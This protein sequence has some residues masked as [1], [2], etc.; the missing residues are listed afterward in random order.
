M[1]SA[2]HRTGRGR[3]N[4]VAN[5]VGETF[6]VGMASIPVDTPN[7][8]WIKPGAPT[9]LGRVPTKLTLLAKRYEY[10]REL[11]RGASAR[12][13]LVRDHRSGTL[14]AAKSVPTESLGL[15]EI[16]LRALEAVAHPNL[17]KVYEL[18]TMARPL[19]APFHLAAGALLIQEFVDG[20]SLELVDDLDWADALDLGVQLARALQALHAAG[21]MHGDVKPSNVMRRSDGTPVLID[22]GLSGPPVIDGLVRGTPGFL[23]PEGWRGVRSVQTDVFALGATLIDLLATARTESGSSIGA[24]E[25]STGPGPSVWQNRPLS[26]DVPPELGR[27]LRS[28][29][30]PRIED[31]PGTMREALLRLEAL[32]GSLKV[33]LSASTEVLRDRT[34]AERAMSARHAPWVGDV[35]LLDAL[36][37]RLERGG[38]VRVGGPEGSGRGRLIQE[39]IGRV[40]ARARAAGRVPP[41]FAR[42]HIVPG[43]VHHFEDSEPDDLEDRL[44]GAD[45]VSLAALG[46]RT[47][48]ALQTAAAD[49]DLQVEPLDE[50]SFERLA[51][52]LGVSAAGVARST[53][54]LAGRL[55]RAV[56]DAL[57]RGEDPNRPG[58]VEGWLA[59]ETAQVA[60]DLL[61]VAQSLALGFELPAH[62]VDPGALRL[63][64]AGVAVLDGPQ[65]RLRD[66]VVRDLVAGL[67]ASERVRCA[68]T[69]LQSYADDPGGR[70]VCAMAR[71][72]VER[73]PSEVLG[74]IELAREAGNPSQAQ[75]LAAHALLFADLDALRVA[76][77][78]AAR[79]LGAYRRAIGWLESGEVAGPRALSPEASAL[80]AEIA[81]RLGDPVHESEAAPSTRAWLAL[82]DNR[83]QDAAPWIEACQDA[84]AAELRAWVHL[85]RG[86]HVAARAALEVGLA[87]CAGSDRL[88]RH[89]RARLLLTAG[90]VDQA[91]G[92]FERSVAQHTQARALAQQIGEAHLA[93]SASANCGTLSLDRGDL[94]AAQQQLSTAGSELMAIGRDRDAARTLANLANLSLLIGDED[95]VSVQLDAAE[96]AAVRAADALCLELCALLRGEVSLRR[97]RVAE[98]LGR[99]DRFTQAGLEARWIALIAPHDLAQA[100]RRL[101]EL[102]PADE[103]EFAYGYAA[104]RVQLAEGAVPDSRRLL[105]LGASHRTWE[106]RLWA[107]LLGAE[108]ADAAGDVARGDGYAAQAR[109][110]LDSAAR[111]LD[112]GARTR[113]RDVA[114]YR[115]AWPVRPTSDTAD[116]GSARWR[117]LLHHA[118]RVTD[119]TRPSAIRKALVSAA[120]ELVAA[121]RGFLV[122]RTPLGE[123]V[124]RAAVPSTRGA[125]EVPSRSV[126][127]RALEAGGPLSTMDALEDERLRQAG[128]VHALALRSVLAVPMPRLAHATGGSEW[129]LYLDDRLRPAAFDAT[130]CALLSDLADIGAIALEGALELRKS[131]RAERSLRAL[132]RSLEGQVE[133]QREE[134]RVRRA[135]DVQGLVVESAKMKAVMDLVRR[136]APSDL[137]V[138]VQGESGV[139]KER[140]A[141]ALHDESHRSTG[142][143]VA[144]S[145]AALPETLLESVLFGHEK[146]AFSGAVQ[147]HRGLFELADGGTLFLDE[148][149]EMGAAMQAKL[150][151]VLQQGE[152]R[153]VGGERVVKVDVR[154]VGAGRAV[155]SDAVEAGRF[156]EDLYYRLAVVTIEVPPLRERVEDIAPLV[157]HLLDRHGRSDLG[158][159]PAAMSA[160]CARSWPGNVRELESE[161][162]RAM[163]VCGD[164]LEV[165][166]LGEAPTLAPSNDGTL[167]LR[168]HLDA[169]ETQLIRAAL[170]RTEG[171][172]TKAAKLLGVSRYGL[173]KKLKRLDIEV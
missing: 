113:M 165:D 126:V 71:W 32:A 16:E 4:P 170:T 81:R 56:A 85:T 68:R 2:E 75:A 134:L 38:V 120:I 169:L 40:Q 168:T 105:E 14:F 114:A 92:M 156:R 72:I 3:V 97:G 87:A 122:E 23:A 154:V 84:V 10:V 12:V 107:A 95:A 135:E 29:V 62:R 65:L 158:I 89:Q 159:A 60:S 111:T 150:L 137:P 125:E 26:A 22:L 152:L 80:R 28:F 143:F 98:A 124:V 21:L 83:P 55:C 79:A 82:S 86:E 43:G 93:A 131:R 133:V 129:V 1:G 37:D 94:G 128:S 112:A 173:Q 31:R 130:D 155:L 41:T 45:V 36:V 8:T 34:H 78:D 15:L 166:H 20:R 73:D 19:G 42:D 118:K 163:L 67:V 52:H 25:P 96:A 171:N 110:L 132:R 9:S 58:V 147:R 144:E 103:A 70:V 49:G 115:R 47:A 48:V 59:T 167:D 108:V 74:A 64:R 24:T 104:A 161:L 100:Q 106:E 18:C 6:R 160:L 151:R 138:L 91:D 153:R 127:A 102:D 13:L 116:D 50:P 35:E 76:A 7:H 17:A 11:G 33:E 164:R 57:D 123:F 30:S 61:E 46:T 139:G 172:Q 140:I 90:S 146:G 142:P 117:R 109:G 77:A 99:G 136:V 162:L 69:L 54:R 119:E 145:C 51:N 121:D 101:G 157:R 63:L 44:R 148:I 27:V 53:G 88:A 5:E 141:R 149:G 66:D 39:A